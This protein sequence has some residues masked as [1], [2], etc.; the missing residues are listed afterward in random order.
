MCPCVRRRIWS[1]HFV[2][3]SAANTGLEGVDWS[4]PVGQARE[5]MRSDRP[6]N[7]A[8]GINNFLPPFLSLALRHRNM[9]GWYFKDFQRKRW[10]KMREYPCL[11]SLEKI[12]DVLALMLWWKSLVFRCF[13]L[14]HE[15]YALCARVCGMIWQTLLAHSDIYICMV[16]ESFCVCVLERGLT[17]S[18]HA[19]IIVFGLLSKVAFFLCHVLIMST[20]HRFKNFKTVSSLTPGDFLNSELNW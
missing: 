7:T 15:V 6:H 3:T 10:A 20:G 5:K 12:S 17:F 18:L 11:S 9:D 1:C 4:P 2:I 16:Y 19:F 14:L 13:I 8:R